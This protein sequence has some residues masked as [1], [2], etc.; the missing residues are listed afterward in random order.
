[1]HPAF[2]NKALIVPSALSNKLHPYQVI[3]PYIL[4]IKTHKH[5]LVR[6]IDITKLLVY[7]NDNNS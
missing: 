4:N 6:F 3:S 1:M 2:S 7:K 5:W